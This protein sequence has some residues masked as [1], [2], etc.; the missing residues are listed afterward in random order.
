[1]NHSIAD[2]TKIEGLIGYTFKN[3]E[4]LSL[5][6]THSS[7]ITNHK[8]IN[9]YNERL[10]FLGDAVLEF[11][12]STL[13]YR[14]HMEWNEGILT[15]TRAKLVCE[16]ALFFTADKLGLNH[17]IKMSQGLEHGKGYKK[18]SIVSDAMEAV[19]GAIYLDSG[20]SDAYAFVENKVYGILEMNSYDILD[21]D[22]KTKLQEIIQKDHRGKLEYETTE[23]SGPDHMKSFTLTVSL[24]GK[25]IGTGFGKNK[26]AAGQDAAKNAIDTITKWNN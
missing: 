20:I 2:I 23:C 3:K 6:L 7:Y 21:T 17:Y 5:A 12:M 24:N 22:Y 4:L 1:M 10:E 14:K 16:D 19:I 13:L 25:I 18:P 11:C 26:R 9:E 15:K 8:N